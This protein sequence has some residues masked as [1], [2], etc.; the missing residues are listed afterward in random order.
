M[1]H[2]NA[3][4]TWP[5]KLLRREERPE[6]LGLVADGAVDEEGGVEVGL[7]DAD[8]GV[9]GRDQSL[10][11]AKVRPPADQIRR[12]ADDSTLAGERGSGPSQRGG[13]SVGGIPSSTQIWLLVWR[14]WISNAGIVDST[15]STRD[16]LWTTVS[17]LI[18]PTFNWSVADLRRPAL[19]ADVLARVG[20]LLLGDA[21]LHVGG[22]QV[23]DQGDHHVVVI[24]DRRLD[25]VGR[26]F[27]VAASG[28]RSR[29]PRT[30]RDPSPSC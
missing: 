3:G 10:G 27:D 26:R 28:P 18:S 12:H 16:V 9:L 13:Q 5:V 14:S 29:F 22:R 1:F 25:E 15:C 4:P 8:L 7:G 6:I 11:R 23:A 17:S 21:I 2:W 20:E 19:D 24:V 30:R